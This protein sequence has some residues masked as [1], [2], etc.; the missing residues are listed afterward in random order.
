MSDI[1]LQNLQEY[2]QS[3]GNSMPIGAQSGVIRNVKVL[4]IESRNGRIYSR[5]ALQHAARLYEGIKVNVNHPRDHVRSARD[6]HD[7]LG[8]LKNVVF[9]D[10]EGLFADLFFNPKHALAEQLI[11]DAQH[12]PENVGLS[13]NVDAELSRRDGLLTVH[14][15]VKVRGVDLVADPATTRGLFEQMEEE[16]LSEQNAGK[17]EE[18]L[19]KDLTC[20]QI[21]LCRPDLVEELRKEDQDLVADLSRKVGELEESLLR[22]EQKHNVNTIL[23][24]VGLPID[25]TKDDA[26]VDSTLIEQMLSCESEAEMRKIACRRLRLVEAA[27]KWRDNPYRQNRK[28][29]AKEQPFYDKPRSEPK[30][31][32]Q[33]VDWIS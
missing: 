22:K 13:H 16:T 9:R 7:R 33:F 25:G 23:K 31:S 1:E 2:A 4:G 11:W 15:I 19:L 27:T 5:D 21:R 12:A 20:D 6:Y 17:S 3:S 14:R 26:V 24:E 29:I 18:V 8:S 32:K 28:C 30:D 10:K